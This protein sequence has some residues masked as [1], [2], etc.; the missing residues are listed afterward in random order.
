MF[1]AAWNGASGL[2]VDPLWSPVSLL[3]VPRDPTG[4]V[5]KMARVFAAIDAA[6]LKLEEYYATPEHES[7]AL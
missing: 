1:G 3:F 4:G 5:V 7:R 2:C 6:F